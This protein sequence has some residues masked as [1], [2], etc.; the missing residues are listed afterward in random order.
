M[1]AATVRSLLIASK[2]PL[3]QAGEQMVE[4]YR[5][6]TKEKAGRLIDLKPVAP[7]TRCDF[8]DGRGRCKKKVSPGAV[9]QWCAAHQQHWKAK[10]CGDKMAN[11]ITQDLGVTKRSKRALET[12]RIS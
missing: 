4:H 10:L 12:S 6:S 5:M 7:R 8:K 1:D 9:Q 11:T 2:R 3:G